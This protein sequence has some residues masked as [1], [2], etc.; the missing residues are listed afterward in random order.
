MI[1]LFSGI[2]SSAIREE[3]HIPPANSFL[4]AF[5]GELGIKVNP[6][7]GIFHTP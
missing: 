5:A 3:P 4:L 2:D 1:H 6:I 7:C